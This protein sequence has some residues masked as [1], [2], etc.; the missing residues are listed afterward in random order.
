MLTFVW[1]QQSIELKYTGPE[2]RQSLR[3]R[4]A[5]WPEILGKTLN[6]GQI[7]KTTWKGLN[8]GILAQFFLKNLNLKNR[9]SKNWNMNSW[10]LKNRNL[11]LKNSKYTWLEH[12]LTPKKLP[13]EKTGLHD[14]L[15]ESSKP[16]LLFRQSYFAS[17]V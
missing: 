16:K 1:H 10:I 17:K 4:A 5:G 13:L 3:F 7:V 11:N 8:F 15:W 6:L 9:N 12:W 14:W 2:H